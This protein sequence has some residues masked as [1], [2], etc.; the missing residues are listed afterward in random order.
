MVAG[1]GSKP[2]ASRYL[3]RCS[4]SKEV[5]QAEL[6]FAVGNVPA[7]EE[8]TGPNA[9]EGPRTPS[10]RAVWGR[11][12]PSI[13]TACFS[14]VRSHFASHGRNSERNGG[15]NSSTAQLP[16]PSHRKP[17]LPRFRKSGTRRHHPAS[18][19]GGTSTADYISRHA[20]RPSLSRFLSG[21]VDKLQDP[22]SVAGPANFFALA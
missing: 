12:G 9:S 11:G 21:P 19:G 4:F 1:P 10:L 8:S 7:K 14:L 15:S 20:M 18:G 3:Q 6:I 16:K 2:S 17:R 5:T 22:Q 13:A